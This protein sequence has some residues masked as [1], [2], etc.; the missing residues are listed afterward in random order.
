MTKIYNTL[1]LLNVDRNSNV[2]RKCFGDAT[3]VDV[4][5]TTL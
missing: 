1:Y 2:A 4:G 3:R 5:N